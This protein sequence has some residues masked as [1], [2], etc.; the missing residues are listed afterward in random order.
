MCVC[1]GGGGSSLSNDTHMTCLP[2]VKTRCVLGQ[3]QK[4]GV[5]Q[6]GVHDFF[7]SLVTWICYIS[8][9]YMHA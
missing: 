3:C 9:Q 5:L 6:L 8:F 2:F 4:N 7:Y 1:V